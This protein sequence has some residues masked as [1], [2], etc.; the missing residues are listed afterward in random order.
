MALLV[1]SLGVLAMSKLQSHLRFHADMARHRSEAV[2][3]AQQDMESLRSF[4]SL[5]PTAAARSLADVQTMS[6]TMSPDAA[7]PSNTSYRLDRSVSDGD[8]FRQVT[9]AVDWPDRSGRHQ[10]ITLQSVIAATPPDLA[11]ALT[12]RP[13]ARPWRPVLGRSPLIPV[14]AKNL[15]NGSSAFKP[16]DAAG[17]AFVFDNTTGMITARCDNVAVETRAIVVAS[18]VDCTPMNG[19]LLSGFVRVSLATPPDAVHPTDL[20]MP[21]D[22]SV[23]LA[24]AGVGPIPQ[25]ST[26]TGERVVAYHCAI[27]PVAGRWSGRSAVVPRGW[28]IGPAA[29]QYKVC[30]YSAD[31]DGSGAIDSN[32]EHPND[33]RDVDRP[34]AQQNFLIVRGDQPCPAPAP[35]LV[36]F[37]N[38][39]TVQHQP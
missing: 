28:T 22:V 12:L 11:G 4:A 9:V 18:L 35:G 24:G 15:G 32:A 23:T 38:F 33:Y 20:A 17:I 21:L 3:M 5:T 29:T 14:G 8:G 39:A 27:S 10:H 37:A 2:R 1:L 30:R 16:S 7:H 6:R 36:D 34:L 31:Q 25:C 26:N 19:M 13:Q